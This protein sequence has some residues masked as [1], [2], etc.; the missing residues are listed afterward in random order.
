[1]IGLTAAGQHAVVRLEGDIDMAMA[2]ALRDALGW[3][4]RHHL[5]V[6]VDLADAGTIDSVG[7]GVLIRGHRRARHRGG[8]MCLAAPSRFLLTV[9]H[10][11]H[12]D[13]VFLVFADQAAALSWLRDG[14]PADTL[15]ASLVTAGTV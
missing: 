10:T 2:P 3:A 9:L 1:M 4:T 12:L 5:G 15:S 8:V 6:V 14:G 11:M 13:G 7:L